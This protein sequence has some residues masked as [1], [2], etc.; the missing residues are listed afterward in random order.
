LD[1]T[2]AEAIARIEKQ[3]PELRDVALKALAWLSY[4]FRP[5]SLRELQ[6]ALTI[7]PGDVELDEESLIEGSSITE[8]CVGLVVIDRS[9]KAMTLVH[10][11]AKHFLEKV[12]QDLF[13]GYH[14]KITLCCATYLNL[15]ELRHATIPEIVERYPLACYAAQYMGDHARHNPEEALQPSILDMIYALL[16]DPQRRKPLLSLLDSLNLL[17]FGLHD[18]VFLKNAFRRVSPA[19]DDDA[20]FDGRSE[21]DSGDD[22]LD[23]EPFGIPAS[24]PRSVAY[25]VS[26]SCCMS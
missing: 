13:P 14:E 22:G 9:T 11:T 2:Y 24:T 3:D 23:G 10:Y 25:E 20:A 26:C 4:T 1:G 15:K 6:H 8:L 5:L 16:T 18:V 19:A 17:A 12:R 21:S 7:E